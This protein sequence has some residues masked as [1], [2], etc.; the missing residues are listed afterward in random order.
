[1]NLRN[2][3]F[4]LSTLLMLSSCNKK[5]K[6]PVDTSFTFETKQ[7]VSSENELDDNEIF[8]QSA[9]IKLQDFVFEGVREQGDSYVTFTETTLDDLLIE[10][11]FSKELVLKKQVPQGTYNSINVSVST[12]SISIQ[13]IVRRNQQNIPFT[14]EYTSAINNRIAARNIDGSSQIIFEKGKPQQATISIDISSW[15]SDVTTEVLDVATFKDYGGNPPQGQP[16]IELII[17]NATNPDIYLNIANKIES[18]I[19]VTF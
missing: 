9:T 8:I 5:W 15:F 19:N 1:M 18:S 2:I 4:V 6:E 3:I 7:G 17:D 14:Y 11:G 12:T 10:N 16:N 13:G